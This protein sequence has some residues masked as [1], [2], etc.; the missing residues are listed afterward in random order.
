[1]LTGRIKVQLVVFVVLALVA[2][3]YLGAKYVGINPFGSGYDV[4]VDLPN[5]GGTFD[6]GEVTYRGVPVGRIG[7]L[8]ATRTGTRLTLHIDGGAPRIPSDVRPFVANRSA[9]GEQYVDLRDG[10]ASATALAGGDTLRAGAESQPPAVDEVLRSGTAFVD[11][12]PTDSLK[13]V[14]DE[15]Y[16]ATQGVGE[17]FGSLLETSQRFEKSADR[18]FVATRGLIENSDR[19]LTTQQGASQSIRSF[20]EDLD[21]IATTLTSSDGGLRR[22]IESSPAAAREVDALFQDV[23]RPLGLLMSNLITPAE[24]FGINAGGVEDALVRAP[25]ALSVGWVI[26]QSRGIN[27][28]FTQNFFN[29]L[30]CTT[31]YGGT[32]VRPGLDTSK[33]QPFNLQAGCRS[34]DPSSNAR[35]PKSVPRLGQLTDGRAPTAKVS[36]A[37]SLADLMGG[38]G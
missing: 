25:R 12:V 6:N 4:T 29:P 37:T 16:D 11:S 2:T 36:T 13:T 3:S 26:S 18:N 32:R 33:G 7:E 15:T 20:S 17:S 22:L 21:T 10:T 1:M 27:L 14:I 38:A 5:A 19:V 31:G 23:G 34:S 30:P 24:V 9:I 35:G 28:G 8:K